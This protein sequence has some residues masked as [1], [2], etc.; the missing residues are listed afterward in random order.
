[1]ILWCTEKKAEAETLLFPP[2]TENV[3]Q[4]EKGYIEE[5]FATELLLLLFLA[6]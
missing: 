4:K 1:M 2:V 6:I 5:G 3:L